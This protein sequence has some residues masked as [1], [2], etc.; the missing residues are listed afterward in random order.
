ML[1]PVSVQADPIAWT[2]YDEFPYPSLPKPATHPA[3]L[4]A[5]ATL[6]GMRPAPVVARGFTGRLGNR[7]AG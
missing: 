6:F 7:G 3:R 1:N 4:A 2:S 5:L